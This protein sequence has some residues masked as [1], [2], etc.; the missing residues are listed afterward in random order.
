MKPNTKYKNICSSR[1]CPWI[2]KLITCKMPV[3]QQ[4]FSQTIKAELKH[5]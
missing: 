3:E 5:N 2:N 1:Y 4:Y